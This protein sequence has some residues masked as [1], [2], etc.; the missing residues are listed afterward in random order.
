MTV[1]FGLLLLESLLLVATV[2]MLVYGIYEGRRRDDL[3]REVGKATKVLTR[4]EYFLSIMEAML[5]AKQEIIGCITG[6][7]ASGDEAKM[8]RHIADAIEDVTR[9][10]VKVSYLL[11]K[12]PDRLQIGVQ[13]TNAGAEVHFSSCLMVHNIR[14]IVV[15]EKSVVLGI[16]ESTGEREAT[17]KGYTVPSEGL[18][19]VLKNYFSGCEDKT[20]L[21]DYVQ[22]VMK[23]TGATLEHLAREFRLDGKDL[24]RIVG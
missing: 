10:G 11:P 3:L 21:A 4:Q 12:F 18:A 8:T 17:K 2:I 6:T 15:D 7:P 14:Y 23:Q 24:K 13:Y 9:K 1:E 20:T 5:D 19:A 16:P 22:E